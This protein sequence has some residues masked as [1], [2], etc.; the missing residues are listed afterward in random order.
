L[1]SLAYVM[2]MNG[3]RHCYRLLVKYILKNKNA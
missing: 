3:R 2:A 1:T